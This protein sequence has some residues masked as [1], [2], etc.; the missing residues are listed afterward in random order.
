MKGTRCP[1]YSL[2]S[3]VDLPDA[4]LEQM[5]WSK[6]VFMNPQLWYGAGGPR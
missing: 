3:A 5:R 4:K 2:F 6:S 1:Y